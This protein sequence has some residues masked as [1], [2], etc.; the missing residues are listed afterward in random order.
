MEGINMDLADFERK[1]GTGLESNYNTRSMDA[2]RLRQLVIKDDLTELYNRRY[3]KERLREE[4][5]R[6]DLQGSPFS[7]LI[8]DVDHFKEVNDNF[9]HVIGDKVLIQVARIIGESVREIDISCRY[10]GDEFVVILP[11]AQEEETEYVIRRIINNLNSFSWEERTGISLPKLTCSVGFT[12]YPDDARDLSQLIKRADKALYLAKKQGRDCWIR[13]KHQSTSGRDDQSGLKLDQT[14]EMIGRVKEREKLLRIIERVKG[15]SGCS[16]IIEGE[17][18][19]GKTRLTQYAM[20][21]LE[22]HGFKSLSIN[23][24][25]ETAEIPYFPLREALSYLEESFKDELRATINELSPGHLRELSRFYP[26]MVVKGLIPNNPDTNTDTSDKYQ[27]YEAFLKLFTHLSRVNPLVVVIDNLQWADF[28]TRKLLDY[29]ARSTANE[30]ILLIGLRRTG[31]MSSIEILDDDAFGGKE[32]VD[33]IKLDNLGRKECDLLA[34]GLMGRENLPEN[35]LETLYNRTAGNPLFV[36]EMIKYLER[37][38]QISGDRFLKN[39]FSVP[40]SVTEMLRGQADA[41]QEDKRSI[42][43]MASTFGVEFSFDLL[44]LLSLKNEGFLLDVIDEA[45]KQRVL[46]EVFHPTE[47]R[48]A[49]VNPLFQQVL[50]E[51]LNKRRRRNLHMQIGGFLEKYYFDRV[52]ELYGELAFHFEHG[53]NMMKALEYTIKAGEKAEKLFANREAILYFD[54]AIQILT[55]DKN[56]DYDHQLFLQLTEKKGDVL[57]LIGEYDESEKVYQNIVGTFVDGEGARKRQARIMGKLGL[58]LDKKGETGRAIKILKEGLKDVDKNEGEEKARLLST[59]AD[60]YLRDGK[61]NEAIKCCTEGLSF[62]QQCGKSVVGAQINM[63]IGCTYL[64]K[65]ESKKA[66]YH[67]KRSIEIYNEVN[68]LKGLGRAFISL[69]T[70][71]YSGGNYEKAEEYYEKSLQL[72]SK[73][74]NVSLL[75]A[76]YNNLGMIER[77]KIHLK[78]AV[79][80]WEKGLALAEKVEHHRNIA[81]LKNNLGNANRELGE[82]SLALRRLGESLK[83][84]ENLKHRLDIKRVNRGLAILYL[85]LW[86]LDKAEEVIRANGPETDEDDHSE[87]VMNQDV[88]GRI[89]TMKKR[90]REAETC[91]LKALKGFRRIGDPEDISVGLL[92]TAEFYLAWDKIDKAMTFLDEGEK[93]AERIQSKKLV[94]LSGY[95]RARSILDQEID[96]EPAIPILKKTFRYYCSLNLPF[97]QMKTAYAMGLAY[98]K[99]GKPNEARREFR[100]AME[101]YQFL[102]QGIFE[103]PLLKRFEEQPLVVKVLSKASEQ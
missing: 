84:F 100:R 85:R 3:F 91:F 60:I 21:R 15:G 63:A 97:W 59:L 42:L 36:E 95:L 78:P 102:K 80:Y 72:A 98:E 87:R 45:V 79:N 62:L 67:L 18:G 19:V 43:A 25:K 26:S 32:N 27:L 58:V 50:Y 82:Y 99:T 68:D 30:S 14:L 74:G 6:G 11:G 9:G 41:I 47:D 101:N 38:E 20:M 31:G 54:R 90:F 71:Y 81:Y 66:K 29:M 92:N 44:M 13:W 70:L 4:K 93:L 28:S 76:C 40:G 89:L 10:A 34:E 75:L 65:G 55:G 96:A 8:L 37:Q 64:E 46:K 83:L 56:E 73:M 51:G 12:C 53:G 22:H 5:R 88:L 23:C 7:L 16:V 57:D 94:A 17:M 77:V 2:H 49:F 48:Y 86:D 61:L 1:R 24:F 39:E 103:D 33:R 35:F 52:E 69:G